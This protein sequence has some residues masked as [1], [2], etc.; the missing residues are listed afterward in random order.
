M[1][2]CNLDR[3]GEGTGSAH[4]SKRRI[5]WHRKTQTTT[6]KGGASATNSNY[7]HPLCR[8]DGSYDSV[9]MTV[10]HERY[11][12]ARSF[13]DFKW[14]THHNPVSPTFDSFIF[15]TRSRFL[16]GSLKYTRRDTSPFSAASWIVPRRCMACRGRGRR[17]G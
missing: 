12:C 7:E 10:S 1:N 13:C 17:G 5:R 16:S 11:P 9:Q 2:V 8:L 4:S 3:H 14:T 15:S 6:K